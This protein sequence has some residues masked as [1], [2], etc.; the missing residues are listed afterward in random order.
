MLAGVEAR[1]QDLDRV[2]QETND[3]RQNFLHD[4]VQH[5][6]MWLIQVLISLLNHVIQ[7][8]Q[9]IFGYFLD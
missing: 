3:H 1:L 7:K 2:L 5:L 6:N 8:R 9:T 4:K